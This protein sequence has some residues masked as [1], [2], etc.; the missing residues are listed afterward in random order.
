[1]S[2]Y[3]GM[4][5]CFKTDGF[6]SGLNTKYKSSETP[7]Q[8]HDETPA[9]LRQ[10]FATEDGTL[11]MKTAFLTTAATSAWTGV[12]LVAFRVIPVFNVPWQ[13]VFPEQKAAGESH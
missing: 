2:P 10:K 12:Q 7:A 1:M 5:L 3:K 13:A 6:E 11:E 9:T 4:H 8:Y